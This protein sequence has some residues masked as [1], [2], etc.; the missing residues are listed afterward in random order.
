MTI[1]FKGGSKHK[2]RKNH[3]VKTRRPDDIRKSD[4]PTALEAYGKVGNAMGN[5]RFTVYCQNRSNS[6]ELVTMLC[7]IR[8]G[9]RRRVKA[10]DYVL[11]TYFGFSDQA[12]IVDVYSI[13][14]LEVLKQNN[15]W[16]FPHED[17]VSNFKETGKNM[18]SDSEP[19]DIAASIDESDKSE[20]SDDDIDCI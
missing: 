12:Q 1:N 10:G 16:D 14:E 3:V 2:R 13:E 19:E 15:Y 5:R 4:D 7:K 6:S 11:V 8:G 17:I 20:A 9:F 18:A